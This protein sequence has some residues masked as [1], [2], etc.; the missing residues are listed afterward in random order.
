MRIPCPLC[1]PR[2]LREFTTRG[3]ALTRRPLPED[4]PEVWD[5]FLHLR[6]NPAGLTEEFWHHLHGCGAFLIV[7]RDTVTHRIDAVRLASED[8]A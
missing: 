8:A 6:D 1:G 4:P 2:D 5:E 3:A 7:R